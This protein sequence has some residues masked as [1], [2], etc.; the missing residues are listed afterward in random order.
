MNNQERFIQVDDYQDANMMTTLNVE[1]KFQLLYFLLACIGF[2]D[3]H[4]SLREFWYL[5]WQILDKI[6]NAISAIEFG[7]YLNSFL[8]EQYFLYYLENI[9][10]R[11]SEVNKTNS[12]K[13]SCL[14]SAKWFLVIHF[15]RSNA[16]W[17]AY[18][19]HSKE[20]IRF[21][22]CRL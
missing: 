13:F 2:V 11:I 15:Q 22:N 10:L 9:S 21:S 8:T 1:S 17:D 3:S 5:V 20:I 18:Q 14:W 4:S 7:N 19:I 6:S 16:A 12:P